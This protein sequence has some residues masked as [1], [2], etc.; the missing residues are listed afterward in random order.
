[1][2]NK[3]KIQALP[4]AGKKVLIRV[5]YNVPLNKDG[6]IAD[7]ARIRESLPTLEFALNAGAAVILMSH[8]GRPKSKKD[9]QYSL[10]VC[11]KRLSQLTASP[12]LFATDCIG[13]DVARMIQD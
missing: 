9:V 13:K 5:D 8:L 4:L 1:M 10:G 7:D 11:A 3:L 2:K 6:S 12:V